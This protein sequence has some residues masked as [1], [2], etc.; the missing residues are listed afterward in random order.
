MIE[1]PEIVHRL[2]EKLPQQA[3]F[4]DMRYGV[5]QD[6]LRHYL[7]QMCSIRW[8]QVLT[9]E[10]IVDEF[11]QL[12]GETEDKQ[13]AVLARSNRIV[14][15]INY[16]I[17]TT[18]TGVKRFPPVIPVNTAYC[19]RW[20]GAQKDIYLAPGCPVTCIVNFDLHRLRKGE[21]GHVET[22]DDNTVIVKFSTAII[23]IRRLP[24]KQ[25]QASF[26]QFPL[27]LAFGLTIERAQGATFDGVI[28]VRNETWSPEEIKNWNNHKDGNG[29]IYFALSRARDLNNCRIG[30]MEFMNFDVDQK[31]WA[32]LIRMRRDCQELMN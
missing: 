21:I 31:V 9:I 10:R 13:I 23:P 17:V 22:F 25:G 26:M 12:S 30:P 1:L 8:D 16:A 24:F 19:H 27:R 32:E 15:D 6:Q 4:I 5:N 18:K 7:A 3:A 2:T 29:E 28:L 14:D 11:L 20:S